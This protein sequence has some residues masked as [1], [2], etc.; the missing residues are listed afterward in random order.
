VYFPANDTSL[1]AIYEGNTITEQFISPNRAAKMFPLH[2]LFHEVL[3]GNLYW[4]HRFRTVH[5]SA[6]ERYIPSSARSAFLLGAHTAAMHLIQ[7][8]EDLFIRCIAIGLK[9]QLL[10]LKRVL[11]SSHKFRWV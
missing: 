6:S 11:F 8:M 5:H 4:L 3:F 10:Y 2:T 7:V 1:S 9:S